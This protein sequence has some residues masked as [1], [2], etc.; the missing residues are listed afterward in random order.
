LINALT[1]QTTINVLRLREI[2]ETK[3][4][5]DAIKERL[6]RLPPTR[7]AGPVA[8]CHSRNLVEE[9]KFSVAPSLPQLA[10]PPIEAE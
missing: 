9:E 8:R 1:V 3:T 6:Q 4:S 5:L 2:F 7:T 10:A